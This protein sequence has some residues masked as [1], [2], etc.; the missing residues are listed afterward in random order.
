[1]MLIYVKLK[2]INYN[3]LYNKMKLMIKMSMYYEN[4]I[5]IYHNN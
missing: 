3:K 1:M 2:K 5:M 4:K